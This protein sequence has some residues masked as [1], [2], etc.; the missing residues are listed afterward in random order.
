MLRGRLA[1]AHDD[2]G[3]GALNAAFQTPPGAS[4]T[5]NGATAPKDLAL[6]PAGG[7]YRF[8]SGF[9]IGG[10]FNGEFASGGITYAGTGTARYTW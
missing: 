9:S 4:F 2:N 10:R 7:E 5:T 1:W 8:A 6:V 3:N